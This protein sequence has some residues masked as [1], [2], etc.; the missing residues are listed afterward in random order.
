M[1][2]KI[3]IRVK[4]SERKKISRESVEAGEEGEVE[5][6]IEKT[7]GVRGRMITNLKPIKTWKELSRFSMRKRLKNYKRT[8]LS[9]KNLSL[10]EKSKESLTHLLE[11]THSTKTK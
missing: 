10:S 9:K 11:T 3:K 8:N 6:R 2:A 4:M 5:G 7:L 1:K